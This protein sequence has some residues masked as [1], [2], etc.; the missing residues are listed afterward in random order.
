MSLSFKPARWA[1]LFLAPILAL[2]ACG[3][4]RSE[5]T[6]AAECNGLPESA[7]HQLRRVQHAAR[8]LRQDHLGLQVQV[9]GRAQRPGGHLPGVLRR[10]DAPG[11]PRR[12][13]L[14]GRRRRA[15]A[16][17]RRG[18]DRRRRT[19][20]PRLDD[21]GR[22]RH[23][24][25]LGGRLRRASRQP[26][27]DQGLERPDQARR[28]GPDARPG[29]ERRRALEPRLGLGLGAPRLRRRDRRTTRPAP[30]P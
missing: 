8:G 15:V 16:R 23:G 11:Q 13:R 12:Q 2:S 3:S 24:H 25:D 1:A 20:H 27:G 26:V 22:R 5:A 7:H 28:G 21:R 14:R 10:L 30:R 19:D 6:T 4:G 17:A 9:E 18:P 29:I